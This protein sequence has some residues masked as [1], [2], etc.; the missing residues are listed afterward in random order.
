MANRGCG[1]GVVNLA[2]GLLG[3]DGDGAGSAVTG[4]VT[5]GSAADDARPAAAAVILYEPAVAILRIKL[6]VQEGDDQAQNGLVF[7]RHELANDLERAGGERDQIA[8]APPGL[9]L[10]IAQGH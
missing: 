8:L 1:Q 4:I 5:F 7:H 3:G 2:V 6:L 9:L 10:G